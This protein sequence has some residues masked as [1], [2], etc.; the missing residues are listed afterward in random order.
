MGAW[1]DHYDVALGYR[2]I[3]VK[4]DLSREDPLAASLMEMGYE[5][6][7][8]LKLAYMLEEPE[9]RSAAGVDAKSGKVI[10]RESGGEESALSY[11]D[12]EGSWARKQ[13]EALAGYG[14][15]WSGGVCH[16]KKELTQIDL[17]TLLVSADGYRYD[18]ET[19]SADELYRRAYQM[20]ILTP[21]ARQ[22]QKHLTRGE[23]VRLLLDCAGFGSTAKL[24]GIFTCSY[25]DREQIPAD[26]L[27]YAALAQGLGIVGKDGSFDAGRTATRAEAAVMLYNFMNR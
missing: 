3:P 21:A 13:L 17:L 4:L 14:I 20:G 2:N 22:D 25:T 6:F 7:Y 5:Y 23:T 8:S 9:G 15:G 26:L 16:P 12:L 1:F 24:Q 10:F 11:S 19:G 27:G 18:P